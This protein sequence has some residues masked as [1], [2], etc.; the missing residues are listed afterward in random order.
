M[1][2]RWGLVFG[3]VLRGCWR[4]IVLPAVLGLY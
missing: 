1:T 4:I 3:A 2:V